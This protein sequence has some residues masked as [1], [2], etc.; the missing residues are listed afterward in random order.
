M[1][2]EYTPGDRSVNH[3]SLAC[4]AI[5]PAPRIFSDFRHVPAIAQRI[6]SKIPAKLA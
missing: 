1:G 2:G 4:R 6:G 5:V 3:S